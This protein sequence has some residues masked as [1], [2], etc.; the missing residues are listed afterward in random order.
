M[1]RAHQLSELASLIATLRARSQ[2]ARVVVRNTERFGLLHLYFDKGRLIH[3]EGHASSPARSLQDLSTWRQGA[4]RIDRIAPTLGPAADPADLES[5]L[6]QALEELQ[7][8]GVVASAPAAHPG[9]APEQASRLRGMTSGPLPLGP[10]G[11]LG[12]GGLSSYPPSASAAPRGGTDPGASPGVLESEVMPGPLLT[13]PQWQ[14]LALVVRQVTEHAGQLLGIQVA[15]K[16]LV[17]AL[18][19]ATPRSAFLSG[20]AIDSTGWLRPIETGY[21][22]RFAPFD[23][24]E[25]VAA[26]LT[27]LES[28]CAG[29]LGE[30][31]A[32]Q[33]IA[34]A[35]APFRAS[36]EQIGITVSEA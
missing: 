22:T 17:Q 13:E 36:L 12:A 21:A 16:L 14:L 34:G 35:M 25:G 11:A 24:A 15:E 23:V 7:R 27:A 10:R 1:E 3:V 9:H 19:R 8:R 32:Q 31:G 29:L 18:A 4:V 33:L 28:L 20:L 26:L 30:R 6:S 5:L 2:A